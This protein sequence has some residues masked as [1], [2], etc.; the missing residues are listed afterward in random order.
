M[1]AK[2]SSGIP[3]PPPDEEVAAAAGSGDAGVGDDEAAVQLAEDI[4]EPVEI[5]DLVKRIEHAVHQQY[6]I[7][8]DTT[9]LIEEAIQSG[10]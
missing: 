8:S 7:A 4:R 5:P 2:Q 3:A 6:D 10:N 9:N 1:R